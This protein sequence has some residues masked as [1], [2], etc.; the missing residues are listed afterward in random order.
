MTIDDAVWGIAFFFLVPVVALFIGV[1][2]KDL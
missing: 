1:L 2:G